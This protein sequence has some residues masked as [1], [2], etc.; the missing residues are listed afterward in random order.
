MALRSRMMAALNYFLCGERKRSTQTLLCSSICIVFLAIPEA[1]ALT[2]AW[3]R[4]KEP[5][6]AGYRLYYGETNSA[7]TKL[8]V[9]NSTSAAVNNLTA[10]KTY[11]FYVTAYNTAALESNPSQR[12]TYSVQQSANVTLRWDPTSDPQFSQY[13]IL[14]RQLDTTNGFTTVATTNTTCTL[15]SLPSGKAYHIWLRAFRPDGSDCDLY[16]EMGPILPAGQ[17]TIWIPKTCVCYTG[18][19]PITNGDWLSGQK[20]GDLGYWV[21]SAPTDD[22]SPYFG[23]MSNAAYWLW[24]DNSTATTALYT[25]DRSKRVAATWYSTNTLTMPIQV[26]DD[27]IHQLAIYFLD[28]ENAGVS[29]L[30][31][32]I[33]VSGIP[34]WPVSISGFSQ[35]GVYLLYKFKGSGTLRIRPKDSTSPYVVMGGLFLD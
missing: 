21:S 30:I 32:F 7:A 29:E 15:Q 2:L 12:I 5:N 33:D 11:Y 20:Y 18:Y 8:D 6:I 16:R 25:P 28:F 35:S 14:Y 1:R 10:G 17:S 4:N 22:R 19:D 23:S 34:T 9:G 27:A 26:T 13:K 3:D 31:D 24:A